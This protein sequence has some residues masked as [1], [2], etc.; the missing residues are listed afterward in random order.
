[1]R[2]DGHRS[3]MIGV[4]PPDGR[5]RGEAE[6]RCPPGSLVLLYTDGLTDVAGYDADERT[7]L[8]ERTFA[9]GGPGATAQ[10]VVDTVLAACKPSRL[11][12][13]VALLAVRLDA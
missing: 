13:D 2:L 9:G 8:V 6:I 7:A 5:G 1:V 4:M 10:T 3:P 11:G 12:D